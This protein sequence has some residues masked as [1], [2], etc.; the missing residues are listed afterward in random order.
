MVLQEFFT[1]REIDMILDSLRIQEDKWKKVS[2]LPI[3]GFGRA[4]EYEKK[5]E[6]K[7]LSEEYADL[8]PKIA[9]MTM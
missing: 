7:I 4:T 1:E 2:E 5:K 9:E 8:Q 3:K 6:R